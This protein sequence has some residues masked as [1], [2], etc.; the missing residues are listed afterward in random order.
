MMPEWNKEDIRYTTDTTEIND[1][2]VSRIAGMYLV[3][4]KFSDNWA[5]YPFAFRNKYGNVYYPSMGKSWVSCLELY[6][7]MDTIP[8]KEIERLS[9]TACYFIAGTENQGAIDLYGNPPTESGLEWDKA[10]NARLKMKKVKNS[11]EYG[12]KLLLNAGYGGTIQQV[13]VKD[14]TDEKSLKVFNDFV[15]MWI[16]AYCRA[17]VWLAIAPHRKNKDAI[18]AIQTDGVYSTVPLDIPTDER[19]GCWEVEEYDWFN[20]L[21][22]GIY[23]YSKKGKVS[24]KQRGWGKSFD[25]NK[26]DDCLRTGKPYSITQ[27]AFITKGFSIHQKNI[28]NGCALQWI[29]VNKDFVPSAASKRDCKPRVV[30]G[31][32]EYL[33]CKPKPNVAYILGQEISKPFKLKFSDVNHDD[34]CKDE[35]YIFEHI[36]GNEDYHAGIEE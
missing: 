1:L 2:I 8:A 4:Y 11:G 15:G 23:Q 34:S 35:K 29:P 28:L 25:F 36:E 26:A 6:A 7:M 27:D 5:F 19:L 21:M 9:I 13:G 12:V 16:T 17:T 30:L 10:Y 3:E 18:I 31:K 22:A 20:N 32:K 24:Q 14:W 33:Y